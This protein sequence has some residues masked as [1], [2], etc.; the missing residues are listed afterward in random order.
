MRRTTNLTCGMVLCCAAFGTSAWAEMRMW[1]AIDGLKRYTC[2]SIDC[3]VTGR[4]FFGESLLVQEIQ[5]EWSRVTHYKSAGC[6][7]GRSAYVESGPAEC[8]PDNGVIQG[9]YAEWV[10]SEF[11]AEKRPEEPMA[12]QG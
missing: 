3:G 2:P 12:V 7:E 11:L 10:K 8:S 6:Y 4:F 5:G 1:V 9:E